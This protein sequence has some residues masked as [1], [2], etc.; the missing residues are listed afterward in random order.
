MKEAAGELNMTVVT[1]IAVGAILAFLTW[2]LPSVVFPAIQNQWN[3]ERD[4]IPISY[5]NINYKNSI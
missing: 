3:N 5:V 2:F 4:P 1:I